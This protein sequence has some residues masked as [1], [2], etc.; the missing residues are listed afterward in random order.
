M[1]LRTAQVG[2]ATTKPFT[3]NS[4]ED[5]IARTLRTGED[6]IE[7]ARTRRVGFQTVMNNENKIPEDYFDAVVSACNDCPKF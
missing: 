6:W 7:A 2:F 4:T 3:P 5:R 1:G